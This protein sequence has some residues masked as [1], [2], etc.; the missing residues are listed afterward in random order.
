MSC[1]IV[2]CL[3]VFVRVCCWLFVV[4]DVVVVVVVGGGGGGGGGGVVGGDS[5]GRV[6]TLSSE[7]DE[8]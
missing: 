1:F 3:L 2:D 8:S 7:D 5:F 6:W 4:V